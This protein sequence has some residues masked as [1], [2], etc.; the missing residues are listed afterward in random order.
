LD[1]APPPDTTAPEAPV[2]AQARD[3][4][5]GIGSLKGDSSHE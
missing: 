2:T 4:S 3:G 1:T 5:L